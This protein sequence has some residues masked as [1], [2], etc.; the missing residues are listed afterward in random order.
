MIYID[1]FG[2][3]S[4]KEYDGGDGCAILSTLLALL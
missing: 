3:P 4:T 1:P 2:I